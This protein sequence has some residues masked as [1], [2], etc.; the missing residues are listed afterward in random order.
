[1]NELKALLEGMYPDIDFSKEKNL[2]GDGIID[3]VHVV[4]IIA[5][6]E[7]LFDISVTMEYIQPPYFQSIETMWE[8]IEEL[9]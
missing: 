2:Y 3:S 6:I 1:M 7:E 4:T 5:K 9:M 8:M